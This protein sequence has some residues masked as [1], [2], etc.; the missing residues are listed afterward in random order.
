MNA[1]DK[2]RY[3]TYTYPATHPDRYNVIGQLFGLTPAPTQ[4]SRVL[5]IGCGDGNNLVALAWSLPGSEF[6][7]IDLASE[8]IAAGQRVIAQL[9][10][11]NIKL[12]NDS[13]TAIDSS[14]GEFD[15]IIA[16]GFYSWV[17]AE[18]RDHFM[19]LCRNRLAPHGIAFVSYN[20]YPGCHMRNMMRE[21]L[22]FH[23]RN[24]TDAETQTQQAR[25][26]LSLL[27]SAQQK[28]NDFRFAEI[29]STLEHSDSHLFHDD[30]AAIN[31]P[32]YFTQFIEHA[33]S[34]GLQF[35]AEADYFEMSDY[36]LPQNVR[37][38]LEPLR[39]NRILREQYL[40]FIK[41]RRFRQT[42]LCRD[43]VQLTEEP[44]T[45]AIESFWL[46]TKAAA[47]QSETGTTIFATPKGA[48]AETDFA[49]GIRALQLLQK[50][51]PGSV[52]FAELLS[53]VARDA[54]AGIVSGKE[55]MPSVTPELLTE[56]LHHVYAAGVIDLQTVPSI[57][58]S[59][60]DDFPVISP[61]VLSQLGYSDFVSTLH[62]DVVHVEDRFAKRMLQLLDGSNSRASIG[63]SLFAYLKEEGALND[64][65]PEE[66]SR[67]EL[68]TNLERKLEL[69]WKAGLLMQSG[70]LSDRAGH[71]GA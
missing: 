12:V 6:V 48:R 66:N 45:G 32:F 8:P 18:I 71:T 16:H 14:W 35:L 38:A 9:N 51:W 39:S 17:P 28:K 25:A 34:H 36:D 43:D 60:V 55:N 44:R 56:F 22:Q 19:S 31:D 57:T 27:A 47:T 23:L 40:D 68:Q 13:I 67:R 1:Y 33:S 52:A 5:E 64:G 70:S 50:A 7:G 3:T 46:S 10:L 61:V 21:M 49:P 59:E 30:L 62:H 58:A 11:P 2:V 26:F 53:M 29:Q 54:A 24:Q 69:L 4:R 15:Y 20:A 37:D 63:D 41:F 42:L 65:I